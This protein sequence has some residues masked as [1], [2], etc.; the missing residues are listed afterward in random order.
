M[1][2]LEDVAFALEEIAGWREPHGRTDVG[3]DSHR[4]QATV[5]RGQPLAGAALFVVTTT[6]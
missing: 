3:T 4:R 1:Y 2:L 5:R 6:R